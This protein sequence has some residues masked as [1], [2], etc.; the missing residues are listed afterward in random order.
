MLSFFGLGHG[1][2]QYYNEILTKDKIETQFKFI[3]ANKLTI[4]WHW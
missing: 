4:Y 1:K 2:E 3:M